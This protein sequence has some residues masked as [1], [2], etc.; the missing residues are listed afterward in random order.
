MKILTLNVHGWMEKNTHQKIKYLAKIIAQKDYDIITLQE[1]NQPIKQKEVSHPRFVKSENEKNTIPLKEK[2]YAGLLI[3]ELEKLNKDYYWSWS[4]SHIGYD[5]YD[6]GLSTL[7]KAPQ[8]TETITVSETTD[9]NSISTRIVLKSEIIIGDKK[10]YVFNGHFSWWKDKNDNFVFKYEWDKVQ[11][12]L[13]NINQENILFMGDFNNEADRIEEG[14]E[15]ILIT[16]PFLKDTHKMAEKKY[17]NSTI[18]VG[19]DGWKN[20]SRGK[21][22][23]YVFTS[24]LLPVMENNVIFDGKNEAVISD[25]FGVEVILGK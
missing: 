13:K 16:T 6:E 20:I 11:E 17:G 23:D 10:W 3:K 19:I 1:V 14:Y 5:L 18:G 7:S 4:A 2:N 15:Y 25:H 12:Y 8:K 24:K 21:R 9:Y 22:I